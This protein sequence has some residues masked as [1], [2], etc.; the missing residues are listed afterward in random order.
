VRAIVAGLPTL[1]SA[2]TG[3]ASDLPEGVA[4]RVSPGPSE[5]AELE[6]LLLRLARDARLRERVS[7]LA[8]AHADARR[9]P[10]P[11]AHAL[12]SLA[13]DV[14]RSRGEAL[15]TFAARRAQEGTLLASVLEEARWGARSSASRT[16]PR[17]SS[18]SSPPA[19]GEAMTA[20][21]LSVVI[22]AYNEERRLPATLA[23]VRAYLRGLGRSTRS[24]WW[25]TARATRPRRWPGRGRRRA[26]L[27]HETNRG[28]GYAVRRGMLA[29][30]G[31]RR[32]ITDADLSTPIEELARLEAEV[33]R[34]STS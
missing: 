15:R 34:A 26:V 8:R 30:T 19:A 6:A 33:E 32:L 12:L 21:S 5:G 27:R 7:A 11:A 17:G 14:E 28:K 25:T 4:V 31:A 3:A 1:V 9:D 16:C 10:A 13:A 23:S 2:G 22:P 24:S 20:P 29:A 18:P